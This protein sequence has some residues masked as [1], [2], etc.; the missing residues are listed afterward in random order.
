MIGRIIVYCELP[1]LLICVFLVYIWTATTV[2]HINPLILKLKIIF[3]QW[4]T[5]PI[6]SLDSEK[7]NR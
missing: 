1:V 6:G 4:T 7:I 5:L 3:F 2:S